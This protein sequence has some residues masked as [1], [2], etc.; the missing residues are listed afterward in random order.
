[1]TKK[2]KEIEI[3]SLAIQESIDRKLDSILKDFK[4]LKFNSNLILSQMRIAE[5][6]FASINSNNSFILELLSGVAIIVAACIFFYEIFHSY[7]LL[8]ALAILMFLL[9]VEL[10]RDERKLNALLKANKYSSKKEIQIIEDNL[11]KLKKD[12]G[13]L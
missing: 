7:I 11:D 10:I 8:V 13:D 5:G 12:F 6:N 9:V 4:I 2:E 3:K 1:M